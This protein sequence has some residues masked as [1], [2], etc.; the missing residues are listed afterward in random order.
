MSSEVNTGG[1]KEMTNS[2][3]ARSCHL[4]S[5]SLSSRSSFI[6][7]AHGAVWEERGSSQKKD[8]HH[9]WYVIYTQSPRRLRRSSSRRAGDRP[10]VYG[11][12]KVEEPS[13]TLLKY[14]SYRSLTD[15]QASSIDEIAQSKIKKL[16]RLTERTE[17][18]DSER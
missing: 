10:P 2:H 5:Y 18:S 6:K 8:G 1:K 13:S 11:R 3:T 12:A 15:S 7:E 4:L 16:V 14:G 9:R 17:V